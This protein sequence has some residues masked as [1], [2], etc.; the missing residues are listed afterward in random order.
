M[1]SR[2]ANTAEGAAPTISR[3]FGDEFRD[4]L[5]AVT[6]FP[7]DICASSCATLRFGMRFLSLQ[8]GKIVNAKLSEVWKMTAEGEAQPSS[9]SG[10]AALE[11]SAKWSSSGRPLD[12]SA[13][14]SKCARA[15]RSRSRVG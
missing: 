7:S 12:S 14:V 1:A 11:I 6:P 2:L 10:V 15:P 4:C 9:R 8:V 13:A 3:R 5:P